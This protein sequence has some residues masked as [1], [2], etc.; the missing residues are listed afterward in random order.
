[1][2]AQTGFQYEGGELVCDGVRAAE[3]A[4]RFGTPCYVYS[5]RLLRER[6]GEI[7]DA[8]SDWDPLVCFSVK[9]LGNLA[10]LRVLARCGSGF[11][12]VSGGE[13]HRVIEAGG[14]PSKIVYAG[15][16]K[17]EPEIELA[18]EVGVRM[19]NVE[20]P[21]ELR[22][23]DAVAGRLG[24][25]ATVA[26]RVNPDVDPHTHEKTT[27]GKKENKFGISIP[28]TQALAR[29]V[30]A[31]TG[32]ELRGLHVHLGSPIYSAEPY[33]LALEKLTALRDELQ[34]QGHTIDT[35]NIGGGYCISYTGEPVIAPADY[36]ATLK[37]SLENLA[38][39]LIIEPG[40][41]V[42]GPSGVLLTR[43]TY[44]KRSDHGKTFII[45]DGGMNDLVR[46]TLYGSYHR[47]WPARCASGMP[48]VMKP[49]DQQYDGLQT[50]TVDVVGPICESGDF[51][52]QDRP[53]PPAKAG[54]VLAVFDAGA[55]GFTMSSNYNAHPRPAEV[56]VDG[57][58]VVLARRRETYED[59]IAAEK[60][61][62]RDPVA[63]AEGRGEQ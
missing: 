20:S 56:L 59:L 29:E 27:T 1:L 8:F 13:I 46:P 61:V 17:T 9:S 22:R 48:A 52:A 60:D 23:I 28:G 35:I 3:L 19:F 37:V 4:E 14:E 21:E 40:R 18:L 5:A 42:S 6:Y 12:V 7:R 44:R 26:V 55:Y 57:E 36:A 30:Q 41:Y 43:V 62:V 45:C 63:E 51:F 16:G 50:E 58:Q 32:V 11:D 15:V 31:M 10:V 38:C 34:T 47:V 24:R 33:R 25:R 54:E 39:N 53:L 49:E 2:R